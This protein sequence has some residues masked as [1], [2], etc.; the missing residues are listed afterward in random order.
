MVSGP[1][2][3]PFAPQVVFFPVS[4]QFLGLSF[5]AL[6]SPILPPAITP[7]TS[8]VGG[9]GQTVG[10]DLAGEQRVNMEGGLLGC[11]SPRPLG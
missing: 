3:K 6:P 1:E 11:R 8:A 4:V 5:K 9:V 7:P 2:P 10:S